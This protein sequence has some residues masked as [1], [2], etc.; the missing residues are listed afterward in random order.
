MHVRLLVFTLVSALLIPQFV[1]AQAPTVSPSERTKFKP[2]L[3]PA[4]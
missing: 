4:H 2:T 3:R 1:L